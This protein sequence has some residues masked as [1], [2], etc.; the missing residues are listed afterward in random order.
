MFSSIKYCSI[1]ST[2]CL[3]KK[4]SFDQGMTKTSKFEM[5]FPASKKRQ[6]KFECSTFFFGR[7]AIYARSCTISATASPKPGG[8]T[9]E[10]RIKS[11]FPENPD[12]V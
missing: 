3:S 11:R 12:S 2:G 6:T 9:S 1:D 8:Y 7:H 5:M 4:K 10:A